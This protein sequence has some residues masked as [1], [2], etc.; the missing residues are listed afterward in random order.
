MVVG[1]LVHHLRSLA[2]AVLLESPLVGLCLQLI[3]V[4]IVR[5]AHL[6]SLWLH[7]LRLHSSEL[8]TRVQQL[9]ILDLEHVL[10]LLLSDEACF[11][12]LACH[13]DLKLRH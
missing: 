6:Q 10:V 11:L 7:H 9:L 13:A 3:V 8:L 1:S 12:L 4:L 2:S 5:I